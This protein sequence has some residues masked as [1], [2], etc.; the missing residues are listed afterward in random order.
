[1][2][3]FLLI[4]TLL[5]RIILQSRGCNC[6]FILWITGWLHPISRTDV[7]ITALLALRILDRLL[8][9]SQFRHALVQPRFPHDLLRQG[10]NFPPCIHQQSPDG[11]FKKLPNPRP[12]ASGKFYHPIW[13]QDNQR[14]DE[15]KKNLQNAN[16]K[17][18]HS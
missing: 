11:R 15:D 2:P 8:H 1:M 5:W 16:T 6:I 14:Q 13:S 3:S 12:H 9:L 7:W 10:L 4:I 17:E 18:I